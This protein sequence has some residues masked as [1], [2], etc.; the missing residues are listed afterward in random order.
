MERNIYGEKT[1]MKKWKKKII[2]LLLPM[3]FV[4]SACSDTA[5]SGDEPLVI[6]AA[7]TEIT[8]TP[9]M[10]QVSDFVSMNKNFTPVYP[11]DMCYNITPSFIADNSDFTIF[12]YNESSESFLLYDDEIY[13]IGRC[14]GGFGITSM[15]LADLNQDHQYEL[16]YTFSWGSG[17]HRS[18]IGYFDPAD[19]EITVLDDFFLF[20]D[21][22][23]TVNKSGDLCVNGTFFDSYSDVN[24]TLEAQSILGTIVHERGK[25]IFHDRRTGTLFQEWDIF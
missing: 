2:S 13:S 14:L 17:I 4:F 19:K 1:I 8:I 3:I 5:D 15:A 6:I 12:K 24:F 10:T 21:I 25:I 11:D 16:Y 22:M 7:E 23:L 9:S 18:Q 20:S